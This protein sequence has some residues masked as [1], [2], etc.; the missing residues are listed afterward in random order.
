VIVFMPT[1][2]PM[3]LALVL[4]I[5]ACVPAPD[6]PLRPDYPPGPLAEWPD[7]E[8]RQLRGPVRRVS[9]SDGTWEEYDRAGHLLRERTS[10]GFRE[11]RY[12]ERGRLTDR[13]TE[14]E[15][16]EDRPDESA[17]Y[18]TR[19]YD[20]AGH[21]V[22]VVI[23]APGSGRVTPVHL[24]LDERGRTTEKWIRAGLDGGTSK[25]TITTFDAGG[26][27]A[28]EVT[29]QADG[30][31]STALLDACGHPATQVVAAD[32][33][34]RPRLASCIVYWRD[35]LGYELRRVQYVAD[36]T[37]TATCTRYDRFG[38]PI[39]VDVR[40]GRDDCGSKL[41]AFETYN[42]TRFR[43][44]YDARGNWISLESESE[45]KQRG[46]ERKVE[47]SRQTR[48]IEYFP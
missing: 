42:I 24:V 31:P 33:T 27:P 1:R 4:S 47:T 22:E 37:P 28:R 36:A 34:G 19:R 6:A 26:F 8:N 40:E 43:R 32:G 17:L 14:R 10:G 5:A 44:E 41:A 13:H 21:T 7:R 45:S 25:V 18:E 30:S 20:A 23:S 9:Q 46:A 39:L 11:Y 15:P 3:L 2:T 12:D 16:G 48:K 29:Y 38:Q 35:E